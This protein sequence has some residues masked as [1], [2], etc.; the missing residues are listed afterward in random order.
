M[1]LEPEAPA[2]VVWFELWVPDVERAKRWYADLFGW[3]FSAMTQYAPDYWQIDGVSGVGGALVSGDAP[4]G[5]ARSGALVYLEVHDLEGVIE[6][7]I[8][9]GGV[10][11]CGRTLIGP[12]AGW[13]GIVRDP[14]GVRLG[15]WTGREA[16][17]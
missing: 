8:A 11:E 1:T 17:G 12:G 16:D 14:D 4:S 6:R 2:G 9:V 3:R 15:L 5:G 13:F 10:L 7:V